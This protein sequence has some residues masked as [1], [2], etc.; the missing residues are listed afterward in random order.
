V[1]ISAQIA[2]QFRDVHFGGNW[3]AV[4]LKNTL[5]DVT[6]QQATTQV[7]SMNTIVTLIYHMNYY[8]RLVTKVLNGGP[9]DGKDEYSFQHPP[10]VSAEDWEKLLSE[11]W[12][13]AENFAALIET[14]PA[15]KLAEIFVLEKYGTYYRNLHGIIEHMHYHLGQIVLIKKILHQSQTVTPGSTA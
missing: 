15:E 10:V 3:T 1:N 2:K 8:T 11:T 4:N 5:K 9:L 7:F 14:L 13:L 6:W 12:E